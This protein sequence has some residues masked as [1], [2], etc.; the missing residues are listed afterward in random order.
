[1][2]RAR[3]RRE[4]RDRER[5]RARSR[6]SVERRLRDQER[7]LS[8]RTRRQR[9][10]RRA[11]RDV[12]G[13]IGFETMWHDGICEVERGLFSQTVSFTD[14]S[15]QSARQEAQEAIFAACCQLYDSFGADSSLQLSV[16]NTPIPAEEVGN[17]AFFDGS[18]PVTGRFAREYNRILNDKMREGVSNLVRTRLITHAVGARDVESAVPMLARVRGGVAGALSR[19]RC[20]V[21]LLDGEARLRAINDLLRPG[22]PL[23]FD[24]SMV[25]PTTGLRTKDL[26]CPDA[27]SSGLMGPRRSC[28]STARGTRR[29]WCAPS[30]SPRRGR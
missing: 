1:M 20:E 13:A 4:A 12:Y 2:S 22:H 26:V 6:R 8:D 27:S 17:R 5:E 30:A 21:E 25:G 7:E 18:D 10:R 3:R 28:A 19:V 15:Y 29:S 16:T 9:R 14:V 11:A 24:W 23:V